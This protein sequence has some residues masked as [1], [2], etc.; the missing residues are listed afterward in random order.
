MGFETLFNNICNESDETE[1]RLPDMS[2]SFTDI[3]FVPM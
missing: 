3:I 2:N 1:I